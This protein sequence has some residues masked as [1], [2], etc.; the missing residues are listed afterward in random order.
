MFGTIFYMRPRPGMEKAIEDLVRREDR[1]RGRPAGAIA[2]YLFRPRS[3]PGEL[4]GVAVFDSETS[5]R[6]NADDPEQDRW[7][8]QLRDLLEADPEW[9]DGDV[10]VAL[11]EPSTVM[12][13][14]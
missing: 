11:N 14:P 7:Y 4:A 9:N 6:R 5:Y 1:E 13:R 2:V 8:R 12:P 3:R 10:L